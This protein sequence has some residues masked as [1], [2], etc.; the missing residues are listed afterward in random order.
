MSSD[1][2]Q[3]AEARLEAA[4]AV[5][6]APADPRPLYRPALRHLRET[7]PTAFARAISFFEETLV[8]AVAAEADALGTWL[9]YGRL[10]VSALAPGRLLEV[11]GTGR[12]REVDDATGACGLVLFLPDSGAAPV[13]VLR[14]PSEAS[15]AQAAT[16]E[17]LVAG[18]VTASGYD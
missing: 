13:L 6:G 12:A 1:L 10:L 4:L 14:Q 8:P 9:E 11:D 7:D 16:I 18:R 15:P 3:R 17:L 5:P 2:K